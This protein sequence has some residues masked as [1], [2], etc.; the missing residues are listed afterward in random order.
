[1]LQWVRNNWKLDA[2]RCNAQTLQ[3]FSCVENVFSC[4]GERIVKD[5]ICEVVRFNCLTKIYYI[6]KYIKSGHKTF[7]FFRKSR[8]CLEWEN[9][10]SLTRMGLPVPKIVAYG[11]QIKDGHFL[12]GAL[13][14]EGVEYSENIAQYLTSNAKRLSNKK[15]LNLVIDQLAYY[16]AKMH[17]QKFIHRDLNLRNILVTTQDSP[18][19]YFIDCPAGGFKRIFWLKHGIIRDLAHLDK[20]AR[21]LLSDKDLLRFYKKYKA[22]DKLSSVDK[23]L[24]AQI[25]HFHDKH[26]EKKSRKTNKLYRVI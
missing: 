24:I 1:M 12:K 20:V 10:V 2:K 4:S 22:I 7:S 23:K 26:R 14:T 25:R 15:W 17:A 9:L 19:I 11:E 13:I 5:R 16:V 21:Y 18:V 3:H 6:K 8:I